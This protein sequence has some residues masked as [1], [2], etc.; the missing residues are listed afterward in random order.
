[1]AGTGEDMTPEAEAK[2]MAETAAAWR[3]TNIAVILSE[4]RRYGLTIAD[5]QEADR[6]P[7]MVNQTSTPILPATGYKVAGT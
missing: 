2:I 5:L 4:M 1:M 3:Q 7:A 6:M